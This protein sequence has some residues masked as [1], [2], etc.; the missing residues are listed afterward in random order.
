MTP[1]VK[2]YRNYILLTQTEMSVRLGISLQSYWKKE[3]GLTPFTD[4]E[5]LYIKNMINDFFPEATIDSIF[6]NE[7]VSKV[8]RKVR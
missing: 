8:S 1:D 5:K 3:N 2:R 6:F 7:K 4:K